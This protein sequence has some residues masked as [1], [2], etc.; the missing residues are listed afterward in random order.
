MQQ[1]KKFDDVEISAKF[2]DA[3][4]TKVEADGKTIFEGTI[5]LYVHHIRD[6]NNL[7]MQLSNI[8]GIAAVK[9]IEEFIE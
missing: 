6:L 8:K 5:D 1:E 2:T 9:R 7:I 3:C 4:W